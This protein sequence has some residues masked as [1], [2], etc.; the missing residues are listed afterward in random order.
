M[1]ETVVPKSLDA[2][3]ML[4]GGKHKGQ[5]ISYIVYTYI[6]YIYIYIHV[7]VHVLTLVQ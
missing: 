4:V 5:V 1:L 6:V 3:V 7:H 2:V